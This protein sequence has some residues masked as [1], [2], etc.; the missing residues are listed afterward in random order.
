MGTR[1][2]TETGISGAASDVFSAAAWLGALWNSSAKAISVSEVE[3]QCDTWGSA[4]GSGDWVET[5]A[6]HV[7]ALVFDLE[8][9]RNADGRDE[10]VVVVP[11]ARFADL[12]AVLE[13]LGEE[14]EEWPWFDEAIYGDAGAQIAVAARELA[15][16]PGRITDTPGLMDVL[17]IHAEH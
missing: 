14:A 5:A 3:W 16:S 2:H 9:T 10:L 11:L 6:W 15:V 7:A 8:T 4:S 12:A 17:R 1:N 13:R